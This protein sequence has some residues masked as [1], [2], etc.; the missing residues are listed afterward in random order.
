MESVF[1]RI[2]LRAR[3]VTR[4]L[5]IVHPE[6]QT[7]KARIRQRRICD[8]QLCLSYLGV[9]QTEIPALGW[10]S[11]SKVPGEQRVGKDFHIIEAAFRPRERR[12]VLAA[13]LKG[14]ANFSPTRWYPFKWITHTVLACMLRE[15]RGN[16][17]AGPRGA[18]GI[19]NET[20]L[21][22]GKERRTTTSAPPAQIFM[23]VANSKWSLPDSS[24]LRMKTGIANCSRDHLRRSR[25][26]EVRG[27]D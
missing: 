12:T 1:I 22:P 8:K 26:G 27:T 10:V 11:K 4:Y 13:V 24:W 20:A 19:S 17:L 23:A 6:H 21:A 5:I 14:R 2:V 7:S 25:L 16:P 15:E 9:V 18:L 3:G